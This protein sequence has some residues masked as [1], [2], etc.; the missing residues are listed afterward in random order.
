VPSTVR[1][2][3]VELTQETKYPDADSTRLTLKLSAPA[4]FALRFRVPSWTKTLAATVNGATV[5]LDADANGWAG[6]RRTWK[7]GDV[8][9]VKIPLTM[10][11]EPIDAQHP[12]R[13]AVV[14]GPV[15]LVLEGAYHD[16]NFRLPFT[17]AELNQWLVPETGSTLASGIWSTGL[18]PE[19]DPVTIFRV[20]LP[21]KLPVRLR[22]RPFY[23][24]GENYPYF[25]Y[26]DRKSLPWKLW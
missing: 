18:A 8:V 24:V 21:D 20:A 12:D 19:K 13:V 11:M 23:E 2:N 1:W 6:I 9:E 17:D 5:S 14:R 4:P 22:F 3:G 16:P 25:M 7:S 26:F 10:R 15:V